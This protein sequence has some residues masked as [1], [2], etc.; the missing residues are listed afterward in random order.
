[1]RRTSPIFEPAKIDVVII[2]GGLGTRLKAA[3]PSLPKGMV[4]INGRPFLE[5]LVECIRRQGFKR[6]IFC[7]GYK[8]ETIKKHFSNY[9]GIFAKFS[10]EEK[11]LGTAGAVKNAE[12]LITSPTF[13]VLN[14]DSLCDID[15]RKLLKTHH[16]GHVDA[17]LTVVSPEKRADGG[18]I[19]LDPMKRVMAFSEK[20]YRKGLF[21]NAGVYAFNNEVFH[22]ITKGKPA[23]LEFDFFPKLASDGILAFPSKKTLYDIGTPERLASFRNKY[24]KTRGTKERLERS[25]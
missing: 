15:L 8:G 13:L 21:L 12:N 16:A 17:T 6:F 19:K 9:P 11:R 10:R 24:R 3:E 4:D 5:I 1:M 23:S 14:G 25:S 18:Y 22:L 7:T 2:C 20:K